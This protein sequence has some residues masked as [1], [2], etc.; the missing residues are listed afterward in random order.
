VTR[1][2]P[3]ESLSAGTSL[4]PPY[5]LGVVTSLVFG[6]VESTCNIND[7]RGQWTIIC[8]IENFS[9]LSMTLGAREVTANTDFDIVVN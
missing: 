6:A 3:V 4:R 7:L 1:T 9:V 2:L 8:I 5:S